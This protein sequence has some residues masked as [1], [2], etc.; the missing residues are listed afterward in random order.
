MD[1]DKRKK[2]DIN[3]TKLFDEILAY[4]DFFNTESFLKNHNTFDAIQIIISN[5][6]SFHN[7]MV[8]LRILLILSVIV[9]NSKCLFFRLKLMDTPMNKYFS[10]KKP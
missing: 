9:E 2:K 5:N 10:L 8:A 3:D 4:K 6:L 1:G 7:L